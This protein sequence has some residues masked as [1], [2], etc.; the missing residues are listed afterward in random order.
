MLCLLLLFPLFLAFSMAG[1]LAWDPY[2]HYHYVPR[3]H[4]YCVPGARVQPV[5]LPPTAPAKSE[6]R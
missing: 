5:M 1:V 6:P 3:Q 4:Y 2:P